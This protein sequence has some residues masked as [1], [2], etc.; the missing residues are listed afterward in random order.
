MKTGGLPSASKPSNTA[1]P[2]P[3]PLDGKGPGLLFSQ[4]KAK[5]ENA[6][7]GNP[8]LLS[9]ANFPSRLVDHQQ[10]VNNYQDKFNNSQKSC[11]HIT[12]T[13]IDN[14]VGDL[15]GIV[16][17]ACHYH[18]LTRLLTPAHASCLLRFKV[19]KIQSYLHSKC[20]LKKRLAQAYRHV[21]DTRVKGH[22]KWFPYEWTLLVI[23]LA[24]KTVSVRLDQ[25]KRIRRFSL[26]CKLDN[27]HTHIDLT[28]DYMT[29]QWKLNRELI[30]RQ[31]HHFRKTAS[32]K[33]T[34]EKAISKINKQIK[35]ALK[36]KSIPQPIYLPWVNEKL[37]DPQSLLMFGQ[38]KLKELKL[39]H[40]DITPVETASNMTC[41]R[42][43]S[44]ILRMA[45]IR[46]LTKEKLLVDRATESL[47]S[48][49]PDAYIYVESRYNPTDESL[50]KSKQVFHCATEEGRGGTTILVRK[51]I[52][53]SFSET[54]IP[55]T[56]L[57]VLHKGKSTVILAGTYLSHRINDKTHKLS[58]I[59]NTL[60][61]LADRY[62]DPT[63]LFFGDLNMNPQAAFRTFERL[64]HQLAYLKL[65]VADNYLS[66]TYF[67]P[68]TTRK[69]INRVNEPVYS[70]LDYI[71]ANEECFIG[72][73]YVENMSDH[74]F[75]N[76]YLNLRHSG[77]RRALSIDRNQINREI[78]TFK[79]EDITSILTYIRDNMNSFKRFRVPKPPI[80]DPL[81]FQISSDQ[82]RLLND[83][84]QDYQTFAKS[85]TELR[86]SIF[87]GLAFKVL[88]SITKYDQFHKRDGS[89]IKALKDH[90]DHIISDP[91]I[92][93]KSL[94]N[95]LKLNDNRFRD[96]V[97]KNWGPLPSLIKP[98]EEELSRIVNKVS[99]HKAL[100]SF[101]VPDEYIKHLA[102]GYRYISLINLWD[103]RTLDEFPQI[104]DCKLIPLNKVHPQAPTVNQ[105]RP[106]VATN[107]LFKV[108]ELRFSEELHLKFWN[109][110]GFAQSQFGFLRQMS[111]QAQIYNLLNQATLGWKRSH[112]KQL[113]RHQSSQLSEI[114][115]NPPHNYIIFIDFKEA[116]NSINM[117]LLYERMLM[118]RIL[119]EDKLTYLFSIYSKLV[120]RLGKESFTPK[121][122]VPQGGVNSPILFNFAM[123]YFLTEAADLINRRIRQSCGLP[124]LPSPMT[125]KL[126]FLWADDLATLL[127]VHP[128]RAK[129]W[130]KIYFEVLIEVGEEWGLTINFNKSAIMDLFTRRI[131]YNHLS[132]HNAI[133]DK[134]KGTELSFD[135]SVKGVQRTIRVPLVTE[136]KYLGVTISRDFTPHAHIQALKKKINFVANSFKSVGG[137]S[138]SLK[139][140]A[141]TWQVFIRPLLDY[142]QTYFSFLEDHHRDALHLLYRE[143]AR[144]MMFL[145]SYTPKCLVEKLIQ[146]NYKEL[147]L[148]F[149]EVAQIKMFGRQSCQSPDDRLL[150]CKVDFHYNRVDLNNV[151]LKW[152]KVWNLLCFPNKS[153]GESQ[154]LKKVLEEQGVD[155]I[156]NFMYKFFVSSLDRDEFVLNMIYNS[157]LSTL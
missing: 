65:K 108:L 80:H 145:K 141:N 142:S 41:D 116:Y 81:I 73:E 143:S 88:R 12:P 60:S 76:L 49:T 40:L 92:I 55:D 147:H 33:L 36:D 18:T 63:I 52:N 123:Y 5:A 135:I 35:Q 91:D 95:R 45:N 71:L 50:T 101:P 34:L 87:Q 136:Y 46:S 98:T 24:H 54:H 17:N 117:N 89:V 152:V 155:N 113:H 128:N 10:P 48:T 13:S 85:V 68:L 148:G 47:L 146:Y 66:P 137:A 109:L 114:R 138:K 31:V 153:Q 38:K 105:M 51:H 102:T 140:C 139:F 7:S 61:R 74:I 133:W 97:Y 23:C 6:N 84:I 77:V 21:L 3:L 104:F 14:F 56:V 16:Y 150:S 79:N 90:D 37:L 72:T 22:H 15:I 86:F 127:K 25:H 29:G 110:K 26:A 130:I 131:S 82:K 9:R 27:L 70:R 122:G 4:R 28:S 149:S 156:D 57:L 93:A 30:R 107:V 78:A 125:P 32:M 144:K 53:V 59:L 154:S 1:H 126:N 58:L 134:A 64:S 96:R 112:G 118:D 94:I 124:N 83:W 62:T 100:T 39:K 157:L 103:P 106:I 69:G 19:T 119:D 11:L 115:Y 121:N 42:E 129:E 2:L 120:I 75:F 99:Q 151:P 111:T 20:Y 44:F 8:P 67:P 43:S 132:D